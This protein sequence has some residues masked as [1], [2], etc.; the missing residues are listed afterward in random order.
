M[1]V[2]NSKSNPFQIWYEELLDRVVNTLKKGV[3]YV[4]PLDQVRSRFNK[5]FDLKIFRSDVEK[6][7]ANNNLS[8]TCRYEKTIL[9][10]TP[11]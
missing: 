6:I 7:C 4:L 1:S 5:L 8:A 9:Y 3:C 11:A 10:I 2:L